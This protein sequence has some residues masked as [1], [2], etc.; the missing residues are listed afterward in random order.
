MNVLRHPLSNL[1]L[2]A[3]FGLCFGVAITAHVAASKIDEMTAKIE[4]E[5]TEF[6]ATY[7]AKAAEAARLGT[8]MSACYDELQR[9]KRIAWPATPAD[10]NQSLYDLANAVRPGLGTAV[11]KLQLAVK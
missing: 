1:L 11:K 6:L 10:P 4:Q 5:R 7:Q 2:G 3:F 8:Q 9:V